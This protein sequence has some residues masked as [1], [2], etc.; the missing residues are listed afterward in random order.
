MGLTG[1]TQSPPMPGPEKW[2]LQQRL[3]ARGKE[4]RVK[5]CRLAL[6]AEH[7]CTLVC[8]DKDLLS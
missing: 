2:D 4:S 8:I 1:V 7:K 5:T 6:W 3:H